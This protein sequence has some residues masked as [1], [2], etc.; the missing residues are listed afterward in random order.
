MTPIEEERIEAVRRY[1][2][3]E[4]TKG[5]YNNLKRTKQWLFKWVNRYNLGD[6]EWYKSYSR[7]PHKIANKMPHEIGNAI[8][9][10]RTKLKNAN[11]F[12]GVLAIQWAM[13]DLGYKNIPSE[14][15]IKRILKR[16]N[17]IE[18]RRSNNRY[19]SKNIPYPK[20]ESNG[21]PNII[22]GMDFLGPRYLKGGFRFYGLNIMDIGTHRV[23]LGISKNQCDYTV[24]D[25]LLSS[26]QRLG[27]P[28]YLQMDNQL[29][30]TG[31]N[32][33]PRAF[34]SVIRLCLYLDVEPI[35]VPIREPYRNGHI[36]RFQQTYK[37]MFLN[38]YY[39]NSPDEL[40]RGLNDFE[41]RH[42]KRYRYSCLR[43]KTPIQALFDSSSNIKKLPEDFQIPDLKERPRQGYVHL[44]RFVRSNK[45]ISVFGEKFAVPEESVYQ[46]VKATIDVKEQNL[47][48]FLNGKIIDEREYR[49][50]KGLNR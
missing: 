46:Y 1:L 19:K 41:K 2:S 31:S 24:V 14:T 17:R 25:T 18:P 50:N 23:A 4:P 9:G 40:L 49:Y 33:Y 45:V 48:L 13:E 7:T 20:I 30:F 37:K 27:I 5:I 10:I 34:G 6:P 11:Q 12:Y 22:H 38:K 39:F 26:W 15:T 28:R 36:E 16:H 35:F 42:N 3:K 21:E 44:I 8:L 43:G 47:L 29:P 32:R